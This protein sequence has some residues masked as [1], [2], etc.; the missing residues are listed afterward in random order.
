[1]SRGI[2]ARETGRALELGGDRVQ[3][4]VLMVRRAEVAQGVMGLG[5]KDFLH[6]REQPRLAN[7]G[8]AREQYR[9]TVAILGLL[10]AS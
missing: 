3:G 2:P 1:M 8:L 4:A 9:P 7:P 5:G 10:P 6:R